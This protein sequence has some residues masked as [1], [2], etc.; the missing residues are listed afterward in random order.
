MISWLNGLQ[1]RAFGDQLLQRRRVLH[2]VLRHH[3]GVGEGA[4]VSQRCLIVLRQAVPLFQVEEGVDGRA[5]FPPA[6]I[7]VVLRDLVQA[8]LQVV[9]GA[10]ELGRID[11]ALFQRRID[12]AAGDLLRHDAELC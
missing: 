3:V 12:V 6:R 4:G 11:R 9:I 8:E 10:D 2:V 5:A 7:V 1:R